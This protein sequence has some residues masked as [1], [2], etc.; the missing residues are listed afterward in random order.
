[1]RRVITT[2]VTVTPITTV[3]SDRSTQQQPK[4][5]GEKPR[6]FVDGAAA[7]GGVAPTALWGA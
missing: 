1:M 3:T 7:E 6:A 2:T 4:A 5:L